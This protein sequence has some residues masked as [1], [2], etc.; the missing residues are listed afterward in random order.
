MA[1]END[2]IHALLQGCPNCSFC[3]VTCRIVFA[4]SRSY[5][6]GSTLTTYGN[7]VREEK[8]GNEAQVLE[9]QSDLLSLHFSTIRQQEWPVL[10]VCGSTSDMRICKTSYSQGISVGR[11]LGLSRFLSN[12]PLRAT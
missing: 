7:E 3:S 4:W 2:G 6:V 8:R 11:L 1:H 12:V 10:S 9:G 5:G